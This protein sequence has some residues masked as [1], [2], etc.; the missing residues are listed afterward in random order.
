MDRFK[1]QHTAVFVAENSSAFGKVQRTAVF[2]AAHRRIKPNQ[3][4]F[5]AFLNK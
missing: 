4:I 3:L 5:Y 1:V 2:V